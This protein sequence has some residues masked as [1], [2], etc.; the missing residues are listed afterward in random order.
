MRPKLPVLLFT[1]IMLIALAWVTAFAQQPPGPPGQG[2]QGKGGRRPPPVILGPP[3]GVQPLPI[4]LF[5]SKNFYKDQGDTGWTSVTTA[6]T[7]RS[8]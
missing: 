2:K 3:E 8:G 7:C 4:D 6:A 5:T 1:F